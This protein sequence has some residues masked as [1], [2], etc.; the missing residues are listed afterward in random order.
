LKFVCKFK[1]GLKAGCSVFQCRCNVQ[2]FS[3][4]PRK[5]FGTDPFCCFWEKH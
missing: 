3:P 4:K 1:G 5:K 2:V